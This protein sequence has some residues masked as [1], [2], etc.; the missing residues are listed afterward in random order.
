MVK[1]KRFIA[2]PI[3]SPVG[4]EWER[5][6]VFNGCGVQDGNNVHLLYRALEKN[7]KLDSIKGLYF[8][9]NKKVEFNGN[10]ELIKKQG[11]YKKLWD[12]QKGGYIGE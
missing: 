10:R 3:I 1:L 7:K 11:M 12:L 5:D 6:A 2:N 8:K 9:K 4:N